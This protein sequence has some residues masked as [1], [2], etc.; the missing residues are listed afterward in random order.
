[1]SIWRENDMK[2]FLVTLKLSL[3]DIRQQSITGV[4]NVKSLIDFA[5]G[6]INPCVELVDY[7]IA[8][9]YTKEITIKEYKEYLKL[10]T[11]YMD[12]LNKSFKISRIMNW[13]ELLSDSV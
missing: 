5:I 2:Y 12:I 3:N 4:I 8:I 9:L 10:D 6:C 13:I 1:M 11:K 7:D